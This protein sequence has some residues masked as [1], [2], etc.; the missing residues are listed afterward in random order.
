MDPVL[1]L[2]LSDERLHEVRRELRWFVARFV[3]ALCVFLFL[4]GPLGIG[5]SLWLLVLFA[6]FKG[7]RVRQSLAAP[8]RRLVLSPWML[9][10][11]GGGG[12]DET[13]ALRDIRRMEVVE[14][15]SGAIESLMVRS[16]AGRTIDIAGFEALDEVVRRLEDA[17]PPTSIRSWKRRSV[18]SEGLGWR[19][20]LT[21]LVPP[22]VLLQLR[23]PGLFLVLLLFVSVIC[24][25]VAGIEGRLGLP[26][27]SAIES[28]LAHRD[29]SGSC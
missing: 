25:A 15:P 6:I 1:T 20:F 28:G 17:R 16:A 11:A 12:S 7:W 10:S 21:A 2:R 13:I 23:N 26:N 29:E 18:D 9:S 5:E 19:L 27:E 14:R 24:V 22:L 4:R 8:N 3:L